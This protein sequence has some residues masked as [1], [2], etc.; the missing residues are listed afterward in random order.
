MVVGAEINHGSWFPGPHQP[1]GGAEWLVA[2]WEPAGVVNFAPTTISLGLVS[3]LPY[4]QSMFFLKSENTLDNLQ[5]FL[6]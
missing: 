3:I 1:R 2:A 5:D 6:F 4:N